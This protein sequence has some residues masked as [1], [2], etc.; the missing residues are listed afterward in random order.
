MYLTPFGA[1][2]RVT[3]V[4]GPCAWFLKVESLSDSSMHS[5]S[6]THLHAFGRGRIGG[7]KRA[8]EHRHIAAETAS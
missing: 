4:L 5:S 6:P 1:V 2:R 3:R 8:H 7:K